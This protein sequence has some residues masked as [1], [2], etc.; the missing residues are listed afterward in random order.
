MPATSEADKIGVY[1]NTDFC[2]VME[3]FHKGLNA[4]VKRWRCLFVFL[5]N[6]GRVSLT[7]LKMT[8][9]CRPAAAGR[10]R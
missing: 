6:E 4:N 8:P 7:T 3:Q 2:F 1:L 9:H 5:A 10:S